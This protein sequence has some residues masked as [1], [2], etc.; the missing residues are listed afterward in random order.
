MKGQ[1]VDVTKISYLVLFIDLYYAA[2]MFSF[3]LVVVD[4]IVFGIS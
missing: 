1:P 2:M 3:L 4:V